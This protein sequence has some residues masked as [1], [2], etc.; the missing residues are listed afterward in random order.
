MHILLV[1]SNSNLNFRI[2]CLI[3]PEAW[4]LAL[5]TG[6]CMLHTRPRQCTNSG[7][8]TE[9]HL[10]RR[11]QISSTTLTKYSETC[12][13]KTQAHEKDIVRVVGRWGVCEPLSSI[14]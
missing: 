7:G 12:L 6:S 13:R 10:A 2:Y 3:I 5:I 11:L 8:T 14:P 9:S 1:S 4:R